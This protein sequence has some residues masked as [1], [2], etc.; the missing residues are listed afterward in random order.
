MAYTFRRHPLSEV[1]CLSRP[2]KSAS[3]HS[4]PSWFY[5]STHICPGTLTFQR[6]LHLCANICKSLVQGRFFFS[7]RLPP[8]SVR[9]TPVWSE[10][11]GEEEE[12]EESGPRSPWLA[13]PPL[14]LPLPPRHKSREYFCGSPASAR[15][16][17][18]RVDLNKLHAS[19]RALARTHARRSSRAPSP[20][21]HPTPA[22]PLLF[23]SLPRLPSSPMYPSVDRGAKVIS[24]GLC[25]APIYLLHLVNSSRLG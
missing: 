9:G 5:T 2:N 13:L 8:A 7:A 3:A 12:D 4:F 17:P 19:T 22:I 14:A 18:S 6:Y 23:F 24:R 15:H 25:G 16:L 20:Q 1:I 21:H 10:R 11:G